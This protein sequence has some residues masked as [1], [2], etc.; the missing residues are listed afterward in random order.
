MALA[1][2]Q[3]NQFNCNVLPQKTSVNIPHTLTLVHIDSTKGYFQVWTMQD[4]RPPPGGD[5]Q[6]HERRGRPEGRR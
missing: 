4:D 6:D 3:F 1:A 5:F 2:P